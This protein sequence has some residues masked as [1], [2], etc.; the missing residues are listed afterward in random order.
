MKKE[1]TLE[2]R[3]TNY[4]SVYIADIW[5]D[6]ST[7]GANAGFALGRSR[8]IPALQLFR[9]IMEA[10]GAK[11]RVELG[12][13]TD[14]TPSLTSCQLAIHYP[15]D[16]VDRL[17]KLLGHI[18]QHRSVELSSVQVIDMLRKSAVG[19]TDQYE[20][21]YN[22][23]VG[24]KDLDSSELYNFLALSISIFVVDFEGYGALVKWLASDNKFDGIRGEDLKYAG[25]GKLKQAW[26]SFDNYGP[27]E[28]STIGKL[29]WAILA[30][31]SDQLH[32]YFEQFY[33]R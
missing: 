1:F 24:V 28:R 25:N 4:K 6:Y 14:F 8:S 30:P 17:S 21:A 13:Y 12:F 22:A 3:L 5:H 20:S 23:W 15:N 26:I 18:P 11:A 7:D 31:I 16:D 19:F 10:I 27:K 29:G 33:E 32:E 2:L 9:P